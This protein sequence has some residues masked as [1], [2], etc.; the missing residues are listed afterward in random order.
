MDETPPGVTAS[1]SRKTKLF[2]FAAPDGAD[3][4]LEAVEIDRVRCCRPTGG[5]GRTGSDRIGTDTQAGV[6]IAG[7]SALSAMPLPAAVIISE[8]STGA[9]TAWNSVG[10]TPLTRLTAR[11]P[12][13]LARTAIGE[14]IGVQRGLG[15]DASKAGAS[16]ALA[17]LLDAGLA[18]TRPV[19]V[20][21]RFGKVSSARLSVE[22]LADCDRRQ[23][24]LLFL[25]PN[26]MEVARTAGGDRRGRTAP[27]RC[28]PD[29][30][31]RDHVP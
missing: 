25:D 10:R 3:A 26:A 9:R 30:R 21:D 23:Y 18:T 28:R 4:M 24:R 19:S 13:E 16:G 11:N 7:Q 6:V 8:P 1:D 22:P 2:R 17:A 29:A 31:T 15:T 12:A 27:T 14:W 20:R 5:H